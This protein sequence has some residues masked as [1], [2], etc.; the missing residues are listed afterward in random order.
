MGNFCWKWNDFELHIRESFKQLRKDKVLFDVTLA[1][2]DGQ[3]IKAH[4]VVL[5]AGSSFF[6]D[7][8]I[9]SDH[10]NML[11]YLKGI[12]GKELEFVTDLLYNGEVLVNQKY[13]HEFVAA[14]KELQLHSIMEGVDERNKQN[15][16]IMDN[17]VD[18]KSQEI[19]SKERQT[20]QTVHDAD[21][22][23]IDHIGN[24]QEATH[25]GLGRSTKSTEESAQVMDQYED[26]NLSVN[27]SRKVTT[28]SNMESST[29]LTDA[30]TYSVVKV[31]VNN[32][33]NRKNDE[34]DNHLEQMVVRN[35]GLWMCKVCGKAGTSRTCIKIHT[36]EHVEG[37]SLSCEKCHKTFPR[38]QRLNDH[39]SR[40]HSGLFSCEFCGK[41]GMN[42]GHYTTHKKKYHR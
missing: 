5:S 42:R 32:P 37:I 12:K 36:E 40:V 34:Y 13:L 8:F 4:K 19:N 15:I 3:F 16:N 41:I 31:D 24:Q 21:K 22:A 2:D 30:M 7:I 11:I 10:S 35:E 26:N 38:K 18:F 9:N 29:N 28:Q 20:E 27:L 6:R 14:A 33:T 25:M 17:E 1:T 23:E 39:V